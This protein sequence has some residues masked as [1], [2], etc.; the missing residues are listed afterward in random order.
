[1]AEPNQ[2]TPVFIPEAKSEQF[3]AGQYSNWLHFLESGI[4]FVAPFEVIIGNTGGQVMN[5]MESDVTRDPLQ[6]LR[7]FIK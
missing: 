1:M 6:N 5:M 7:Q 2:L 3:Q 4:L